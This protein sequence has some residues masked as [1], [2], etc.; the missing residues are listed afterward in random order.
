M[1]GLVRDLLDQA[2]HLATKEPK[3]PRQASLRRAVSNAYYAVFHY[4]VRDAARFLV[5]GNAEH[6]QQLR[7]KLERSFN[8]GEMRKAAQ[9]LAQGDSGPW[10]DATPN[11]PPALRHVAET[12]IALQQERHEADYSRR[13]FTRSEVLGIVARSRR[14]VADWRTVRS[15]PEAEAFRLALLRLPTR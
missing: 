12:F 9:P 15:T 8:H 3:R 14:A 11:I 10:F 13:S 2:E 6:R 7:A 5:S 1:T 4:L